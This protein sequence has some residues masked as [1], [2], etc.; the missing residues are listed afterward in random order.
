M[1]EAPMQK[2]LHEKVW[3]EN[4]TFRIGCKAC[5]LKPGR[6]R[7]CNCNYK[8]STWR[9]RTKNPMTMS[10]G[11]YLGWAIWVSRRQEKTGA[12]KE[13]RPFKCS[14]II[15][16]SWIDWTDLTAPK[17]NLGNDQY[18]S[19]KIAVL[20]TRDTWRRWCAWQMLGKIA[21]H[22]SQH[23]VRICRIG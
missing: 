2:A 3:K 19:R 13:R 4:N 5:I 14:I 17:N 18:F 21:S 6:H 7:R 9:M 22:K 1:T 15:S 8:K 12:N 11:C 16:A 20:Q 10:D 23:N